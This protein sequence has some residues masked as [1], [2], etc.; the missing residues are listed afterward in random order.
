MSSGSTGWQLPA[1][2]D[3]A[4]L[5]EDLEPPTRSHRR[6]T[7]SPSA[8]ARAAAGLSDHDRAILGSLLDLRYLTTRQIDRL[9]TQTDPTLK[10]HTAAR[11]TQRSMTRLEALGLVDKLARRI[12]GVRPGSASFIWRLSPAGARLLG[13]PAQRAAHG[14]A[15]LAHSLD[16]AEVVVRLRE[17]ERRTPDLAVVAIETEP[18]CWRRYNTPHGTKGW[19]RPDLRVTLRV[20]GGELHWFVEV[21]RGTEHRRA[22]SRKI[23]GYLAVWR[24]G[25][26]HV[27][28]GVF[29]GVLWVVPDDRRAAELRGVWESTVGVPA[30]MMAAALRDD[31]VTALTELPR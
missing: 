26:E 14:F 23:A 27:R 25:G 29:P 19:L 2:F 6:P 21:D 16:V 9:H 20:V 7:I 1:P 18:T 17:L 13:A 30:G 11:R 3:P 8:L 31:A 5:A 15:H 28:A 4:P 10:P 24:G 12:G 22:L